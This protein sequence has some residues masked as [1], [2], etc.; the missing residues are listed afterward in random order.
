MSTGSLAAR[1]APRLAVFVGVAMAGSLWGC[2]EARDAAGGLRVDRDTVAGVVHVRHTG[3][4]PASALEPLAAVGRAGSVGAAPSPEEL[5]RVR[6]VI[7]DADGRMYVADGMALE[8]RVFEPDGRFARRMG[9]RGQGPG[10]LEGVHGVAWLAGDTLVALD[11]GNARVSVLTAAWEP[12]GQWPWMRLTGSARFL[13]NG[14]PGEVYVHV[15][16]RGVEGDG[17]QPAWARFTPE[18]PGDTVAIPRVEPRPGTS[19][20]CRGRGIGFYEN[21]YGDRLLSAPAPN[22][23]RVLGWTSAYRLAFI[24][25]AGD[26]TRVLT[27]DIAPVP[28]PDSAWDPVA[29]D[30]ARFR[31]EWRGAA[32]EGDIV[33]PDA[34]RVLTDLVFDHDGGLVVEYTTPAGRAFD[35]YGPDGALRATFPS[36]PDRDPSV[37]PFLRGDRLYLVTKDSLDIQRARAYR[38]R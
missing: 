25:G 29:A 32:C 33:R 2:G 21:P 7:A 26:T 13:F 35:R 14:G 34:R 23:E 10:E 36:P 27:R 12:V 28:L 11:Y 16:Q 3:S 9:R 4:L 31:E 30:L 37:P 19:L 22:G 6:S 18:G 15:F 20:V 24:D 5:G 8:V 1:L 38:I 17:L